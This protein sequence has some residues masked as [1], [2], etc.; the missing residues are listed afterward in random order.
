MCFQRA[1]KVKNH[2]RAGGSRNSLR[3][4]SVEELSNVPGHALIQQGKPFILGIQMVSW[5][6][7][8]QAE[9]GYRTEKAFFIQDE[10]LS[11]RESGLERQYHFCGGFIAHIERAGSLLEK[12]HVRISMG[13]MS[14]QIS[15]AQSSLS[16]LTDCE[17][18]I[19]GRLSIGRCFIFHTFLS[20][21]SNVM[22]QQEDRWQRGI[23]YG[24]LNS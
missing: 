1:V 23:L 2:D 19:F 9:L 8:Y 13:R 7:N 14:F 10:R 6:S 20:M 15:E 18:K 12:D 17:C 5:T 3:L 16:S 24:N 4:S 21:E 22:L 11:P